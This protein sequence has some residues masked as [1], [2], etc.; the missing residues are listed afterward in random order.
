MTVPI[1]N[2]LKLPPGA[3][4]FEAAYAWP[5]TPAAPR[6]QFAQTV[7][8]ATRPRNVIDAREVQ[9]KNALS[10]MY[11]TPLPMVTE[12]REVHSLNV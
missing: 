3:G 8:G 11:V 10:P 2:P 6:V 7:V 9:R 5:I 1:V 4:K 12:V